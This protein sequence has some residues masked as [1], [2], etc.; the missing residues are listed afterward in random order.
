MARQLHCRL[1]QEF[2]EE[3]LEAFNEGR[4]TEEQAQ[5]LLG[6]KRTR[7]YLLRREWLFKSYKG[8][9]TLSK[10]RG[11]PGPRFH[12]EAEHWL[13]QELAFIRDEAG[14][15]F[16]NRFNFAHLAERAEQRFHRSFPRNSLRRWA[17]RHGY[18]QGDP[19]QTRKV[20][21]RFETSA[22]GV[23]FQHDSSRHIWLPYT[24]EYS[25]LIATQDDHSRKVVGGL[26]VASETAWE[27]LVVA[28]ETL[29]S[30]GRPSVKDPCGTGLLCGPAQHPPLRGAPRGPRLLPAPSG[31]GTGSVSP[32]PG[33]VGYR[34]HLCSQPGS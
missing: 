11:R 31:P 26:L 9:F 28:R 22:P 25:T 6:I 21:T 32:C 1:P 20:F 17:I 4:V 19:E 10:H 24:R 12:P 14:H 23:L 34:D 13:H 7:L 2:V 8:E 30:Y 15:G 33:R 18:Y 3:I 29:E 27:H 5:A 16:R